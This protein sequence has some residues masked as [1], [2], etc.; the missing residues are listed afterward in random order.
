MLHK[1]LCLACFGLLVMLLATQTAQA[2]EISIDMGDGGSLTV[3]ALQ[4]IALITVLSLAPGLAVMITCFPFVVTVLSILRQAIGLQQSPP[5]MLIVSLA[6]FLTYFV[7]A[8]VFQD[9]YTQGIAPLIDGTLTPE[10]AIPL[11]YAPFRA[12]MEARV[13][14]ETLRGMMELRN[15]PV[16]ASPDP[17]VLIPSFMLSEVERAFQI[18]FLI[19]LPFLI[20]DLVV[21]AILMSMGMMMVPPA[22]VSM[23][24]KLAFFVVADGWALITSALVRSYF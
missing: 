3:R 20:I 15:A 22:I 18:G 21:A 6:L 11:A 14:P 16:D 8:P 10:S 19:F 12:F 1:R 17:S 5:N 13:D 7:M 4:L 24:F 23:P 2:Q 9:A